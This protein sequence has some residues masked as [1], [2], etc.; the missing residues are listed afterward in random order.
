MLS[1]ALVALALAQAVASYVTGQTPLSPAAN[2]DVQL[3]SSESEAC[4][5]YDIL[6]PKDTKVDKALEELYSTPEFKAKT[7]DALSA[8]IRVP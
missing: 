5:Q 2:L 7:N 6:F 3:A 8:I 1:K 4:K